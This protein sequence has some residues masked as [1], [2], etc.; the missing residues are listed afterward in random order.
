LTFLEHT[1]K[2]IESLSF[3]PISEAIGMQSMEDI[4]V[5]TNALP[6]KATAFSLK[7]LNNRLMNSNYLLVDF[8]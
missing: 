4:N 2:E 1:E 6:V 8:F 3:N 5:N 7:K